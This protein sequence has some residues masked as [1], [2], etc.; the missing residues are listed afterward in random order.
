MLK[1]YACVAG[2][3]RKACVVIIW[4][5]PSI[6]LQLLLLVVMPKLVQMIVLLL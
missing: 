2:W 6:M 5:T 3:A 1:V 4:F